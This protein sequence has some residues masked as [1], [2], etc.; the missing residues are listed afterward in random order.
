MTE[1]ELDDLEYQ[2]RVV[3][4]FDNASRGKALIHFLSPDSEE[5]KSVQ[6]VLQ[7]S[8]IADELY[9]YKPADVTKLVRKVSG[10]GFSVNEHT[11]AW[12]KHQVRPTSRSKSP[13]KDGPGLLHLSPRSSRLQL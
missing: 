2:F 1:Q 12:K 9:Q 10:K 6:N 4:A 3:Y 13:E 11:N 5:G 7:K 8:K